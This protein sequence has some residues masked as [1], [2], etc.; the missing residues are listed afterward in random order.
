V[1]QGAEFYDS[2]QTI[3][4]NDANSRAFIDLPFSQK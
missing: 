3:L 4:C 2:R 1:N